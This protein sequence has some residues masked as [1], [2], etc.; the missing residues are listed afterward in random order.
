MPSDLLPLGF[1][2]RDGYNLRRTTDAPR[3]W[4]VLDKGAG[5]KTDRRRTVAVLHPAELVRLPERY[6]EAVA[7]APEAAWRELTAEQLAGC[8]RYLSNRQLGVVKRIRDGA[9]VP[10]IAAETGECPAKL[11]DLLAW[12]EQNIKHVLDLEE[13]T[14]ISPKVA[15]VSR[16]RMTILRLILR[17]GPACAWCGKDLAGSADFTSDHVV[18]RRYGQKGSR[19]G[20]PKGHNGISNL[21]LACA[22]CNFERGSMPA[23]DFYD[24]CIAFG[25]DVQ[26]HLVSAAIG[27]R[28]GRCDV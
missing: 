7:T 6:P 27:R 1:T 19:P 13:L 8:A 24:R 20:S 22:R 11:R 5:T 16:R 25:R 9:S 17:D 4:Y 23:E 10:E 15:Q 12:G 14:D 18:P 3:A 26:H 28:E 21:L 2:L